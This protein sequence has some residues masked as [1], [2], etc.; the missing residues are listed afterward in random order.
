MRFVRSLRDML[1]LGASERQAAGVV[2]AQPNYV[3][4]LQGEENAAT[5][6]TRDQLIES[7]AQGLA[8]YRRVMGAAQRIEA[9]MNTPPDD[10]VFNEG[11]EKYFNDMQAIV[12]RVR[13]G[14]RLT[15]PS[16]GDT[17]DRSASRSMRGYENDLV[18]DRF[19]GFFPPINDMLTRD[20][21]ALR[22]RC[23]GH[24]SEA[25]TAAWGEVDANMKQASHFSA[26]AAQYSQQIK[27]AK[28][29]AAAG[30]G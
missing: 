28:Q 16:E 23:T 20:L 13:D 14:R 26:E 11:M 6:A 18:D 24:M 8:C 29:S 3:E 27:A 25:Q 2:M 17:L 9:E 15:A 19:A 22:E 5:V 12:E 10:R 30:K 1:A 21:N 7:T 4:R